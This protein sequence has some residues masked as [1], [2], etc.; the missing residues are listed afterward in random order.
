VRAWLLCLALTGC[1]DLIGTFP[2]SHPYVPPEAGETAEAATVE[3]DAGEDAQK[4]ETSTVDTFVPPVV[5]AAAEAACVGVL[6]TC[7]YLG[8]PGPCTDGAYLYEYRCP[9]PQ[10]LPSNCMQLNESTCCEP[11]Q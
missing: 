10:C 3:P 2:E 9:D 5:D 7:T 8:S 11:P 6:N 1:A 4:E